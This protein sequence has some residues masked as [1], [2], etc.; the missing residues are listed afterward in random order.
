MKTIL[1]K[2]WATFAGASVAAFILLCFAFKLCAQTPPGL[3][4]NSAGTNQYVVV[5]TNA[6]STNSYELYWTPSLADPDYPWQLIALGTNGI[7]NFNVNGEGY[8]AGFFKAQIEQFYSGIPDYELADPNNPA[9]G[10]LTVTI[11][12]PANGSTVQ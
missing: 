1:Q 11:D 7:T 8:S 3:A 10:A 5:I 9:A 4:I 6:I 12:T 2:Y